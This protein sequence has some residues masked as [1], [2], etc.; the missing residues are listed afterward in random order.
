M[1]CI[2]CDCKEDEIAEREQVRKNQEQFNNQKLQEL[3]DSHC[4]DIFQLADELDIKYK[5]I[6]NVDEVFAICL[7]K[8]KELK[9]RLA[10]C[11]ENASKQD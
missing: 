7:F 8:I 1:P 9:V 11:F 10:D 5:D 2:D 3:I 4:E 6:P